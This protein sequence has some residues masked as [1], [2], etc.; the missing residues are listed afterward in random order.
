M[1]GP[2]LRLFRGSDRHVLEFR[3]SVIVSSF[4]PIVPR[5]FM[6]YDRISSR[7]RKPT[8]SPKVKP[9]MYRNFRRPI[10]ALAVFGMIFVQSA[11]GADPGE[12]SFARDVLPILSDRCF[13]C[14]G[15][16][17]ANRKA[18]LRLDDQKEALKS[19]VI[20]P[21]KPAESELVARI[22]SHDSEEVMPPP[23]F[24]KPLTSKQ[25]DTLKAWVAGGA[26]WGR[27]WAWD[28]PA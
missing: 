4:F 10:I 12:I 11:H 1:S 3:N 5:R 23:K 28:V 25:I 20:E 22:E 15:P 6:A 19:G 16:D 18:E 8:R 27:H 24:G 2:I 26:K 17:K 9:A 14:H 13:A 21:G 7:P